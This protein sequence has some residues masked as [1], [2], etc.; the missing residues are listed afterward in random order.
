MAAEKTLERVYDQR[1]S[2][3]VKKLIAVCEKEGL[4]F[5]MGFGI[6]E[7]KLCTSL[8]LRPEAP[9]QLVLA[10]R[11]LQRGITGFLDL[12]EAG[13]VEPEASAQPDFVVGDGEDAPEDARQDED[14]D[15]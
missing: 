12:G 3:L 7:G 15:E 6:G 4:D 14:N 11:M 1:V 9:D 8:S 10:A 2:P 13:E 5:V